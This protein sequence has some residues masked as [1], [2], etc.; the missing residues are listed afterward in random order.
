MA[1]RST[2][3]LNVNGTAHTLEVEHRETLLHV[4]R[5]RLDLTGAKRACDRGECG[6]CAVLLDERP[7]NACQLLAV[8]VGARGV[9]TIEGLAARSDFGPILKS[10]V[11][12]DGGQCGY[13][14]PGMA[15]AA[16]SALQRH[17]EPNEWALRWEMVGH[18]CRCN[19]Y[20]R[21]V[22]SVLKAGGG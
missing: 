5:E 8:Q 16:Y 14:I 6:A 10:M 18:L 12:S 3:T 22:D 21:I 4:L 2:I 20:E 1:P 13:C 15:V 19:A 7:F 9:T 11:A 17:P